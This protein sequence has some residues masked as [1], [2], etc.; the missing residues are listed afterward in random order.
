MDAARAAGLG[1]TATLWKT[2]TRPSGSGQGGGSAEI[3]RL[4]DVEGQGTGTIRRSI[5]YPIMLG[6][7]VQGTGK[8]PESPDT[9]G[10]GELETIFDPGIGTCLPREI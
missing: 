10:M 6:E 3:R 5:T 7:N 8:I 2:A 9:I 4:K 1:A